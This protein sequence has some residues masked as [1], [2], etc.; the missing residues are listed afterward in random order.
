MPIY[1]YT[2]SDDPSGFFTHAQGINDGGQIVGH[3]RNDSGNH[4]FLLSGGTY[5][6]IDDPLEAGGVIPGQG[7]GTDAEG[8]NDAGQIVGYYYDSNGITHG[9]LYNPT[10]GGTYTTLDAPLATNTQALGINN[11]GQIV[12]YYTDSHGTSHGF[13]YNTNSKLYATLDDPSA[14]TGTVA[15]GI[16]AAGQIVGYYTNASG[17]HGF[18]YNPNGGTYTTL[19]DPAGSTFATGINDLGQIVGYYLGPSAFHG[20]LLTGSAYITIDDPLNRKASP[21][22]GTPAG[23]LANGINNAGQITGTYFDVN[24]VA[25]GFLEFTTP[26]PPPPAGTTADMILGRADGQYEI[27]DIGNNA[28]L[29]A[30]QLGIVGTDYKYVA[31]GNFN[32]TDTTDMLLRSSSN[33]AFEVYNINNN[34]ITNAAA[35]GA[36]GLNWG[37]VG[38]GDFNADGTSDMILRNSA[39]GQ[40]EV[41]DIN[42]N[43][44]SF[45]TSLGTVGLEWQVAGVGDFDGDG[46]TDM[47]LRNGNTGQFEVYNIRNNAISS[48]EPLGTVGTDWFVGGFR[49]FNGDGTTDMM[50]WN[51]PP[52]GAPTRYELYDIRNNTLV[53]AHAI[54]T[55]GQEWALAG[56]GPISDQS[57]M[58][59]RNRRTGA[60]EVYD[61]ANDALSS[62]S[63][64]GQVGLDWQL[65]GFA[66]DPPSG[67]TGS[68]DGS[69]SQL[70]QA[71]AGFDGSSG[72]GDS[73]NAAALSEADMSQQSLLTSSQHG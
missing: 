58:V 55:V 17:T 60:F 37:F 21:G 18:F 43:Q 9:F 45:A 27:Y 69:T 6:I 10:G 51:A 42:N 26:N 50:L 49:D 54:G 61:I 63:S 64:L 70:V 53:G 1:N 19:D 20:F 36:I 56:F 57:D 11:F 41:Y 47:M 28:L 72:A 15:T 33:G 34:Q 30:Y 3:Y 8:I 12:G 4:G 40:F 39:S 16:N 38:L 67:A 71:M 25:N 62:A 66:A 31:L 73:L 22:D 2:T 59:L 65:G 68:P 32:G 14:A 44:I 48:A 13:L 29:A 35:L 52:T 5:T 46:A 7:T 23:T 24:A